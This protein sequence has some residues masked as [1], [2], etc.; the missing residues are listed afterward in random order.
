VRSN[1]VCCAELT[2]GREVTF[3]VIP[4]SIPR[5]AIAIIQF[6][7]IYFHQTTLYGV[8]RDYLPITIFKGYYFAMF[9]HNGLTAPIA[10]IFTIIK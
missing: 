6:V 5:M 2:T 8:V 3:N 9:S 10:N 1:N 7:F 4:R